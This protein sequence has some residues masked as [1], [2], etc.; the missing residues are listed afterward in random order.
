MTDIIILI[1]AVPFAIVIGV[2]RAAR[3]IY[4][5]LSSTARSI[6]ARGAAPT[7]GAAMNGVEW[8]LMCMAAKLMPR[9]AGW[10]WLA[11]AESFL[12]EAPHDLQRGAIDNY[13]ASVPRVIMISWAGELVRRVRVTGDG[14]R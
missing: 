1:F 2:F 13:L 9:A 7:M 14:S 8:K 11:E 4:R 5:A 12:A 10:R 3:W 6:M